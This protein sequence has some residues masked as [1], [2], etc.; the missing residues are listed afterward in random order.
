MSWSQRTPRLS[1]R[2]FL[3]AVF[4][5]SF[6]GLAAQAAAQV[7]CNETTCEQW[8]RW[9][10]ELRSAQDYQ[11]NDNPYRKLNI[12]VTYTPTSCAGSPWC[13]SFTG[14][15]FWDG[16]RVFRI[17]SAF[18]Q[19]TWH[20]ST[21]CSGTSN[22][23]NCATDPALNT[24]GD[25]TVV[26]NSVQDDP[27]KPD[28][29][30]LLERGFVR[31]STNSGLK[32]LTYG[33][34]Q[35]VFHWRA[36]TSWSA[37]IKDYLAGDHT[38]TKWNQFLDDRRNKGFTVIMM[39]SGS[40]A[41]DPAVATTHLFEDITAPGDPPCSGAA[42][43]R[44]CSRWRPLAFWQRLDEKIRLANEKGF[45][46][47][48]IGVMDPQGN[49]SNQPADLKYPNA[50]DAAI[51]ARNLSA[52]LAGSHVIYSPSFDDP[53][54]A[55]SSLIDTVGTALRNAAPRHLVTAHLAGASSIC[56]YYSLH[57]R[58][59]HQLHVFQSGHALNMS[60]CVAGEDAY[61]CAMRRARDIPDQLSPTPVVVPSCGGIPGPTAT[62]VKPNANGEAAYDATYTRANPQTV[63]SPYGV[64]HSGYNSALNGAFGVTLGVLGLYNWTN[65]SA[66]TLDSDGSKHMKILGDQFDLQPWQMLQRRSLRIKNQPPDT[67]QDQKMTLAATLDGNFAMAYMP[68]NVELKFDGTFLTG[69]DCTTAAWTVTWVNPK[70]GLPGGPGTCT[71]ISEP[72]GATRKLT[73][74][75]CT[76][77]GSLG[78]CDWVVVLRRVGFFGASA[79]LQ[80][81]GLEVWPAPT[82]DGSGWRIAARRK[83]VA[84][85]APGEEIAL[86]APAAR[87]Q[88]L[89]LP[90]VAAEA[91]GSYFV[92]WESGNDGDL[93]GIF[94]RRV[95]GQGR[96]L[97]RENAVNVTKEHDQTN[98]WAAASPTGRGGVVTWTSY[99]QDGDLG[100]VF[101]RLVDAAGVPYGKEIPVNGHTAGRQD[102]SK[103][104]M[105]D[106][107]GFVVAWTS[108]GQDGDAEGV[109]V[110]RFDAQGAP[111]GPE[112]RVNT[113]TA[114]AQWLTSLE[115]GAQGDVLVTWTS[116]APD[117]SELGVFGQRYD[118]KGLPVGGEYV[119]VPPPAPYK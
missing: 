26:N 103:A 47:V 104:V 23:L 97:G 25:V 64:R 69:F 60:N 56:D 83:G 58:S 8:Y 35:S 119:V 41:D 90:V 50:A 45:L 107:G 29:Y 18:P 63:D 40:S 13:Q 62:D 2:T 44:S 72:S 28:R 115:P 117:G 98:P 75:N 14:H 27:T 11:V 88:R 116:Y 46:V 81:S 118:A 106:R 12:T 21:S 70:T 109:Y 9:E 52:R 34:G 110:R 4:L 32:Y 7:T 71:N 48:L 24:S 30:D 38:N 78:D 55:T 91:G 31:M 22:G 89:K 80:G 85:S 101:A 67:D 16:G 99:G 76:G 74:P 105:D 39:A 59:W 15:G 95:D 113:T 5:F 42:Y 6:L 1:H 20:W 65:V 54:S 33:D 66:T 111:L 114:G 77:T 82:P 3:S 49:A 73:R 108:D 19:G 43:P 57:G 68:D 10:K 93:H 84:G 51:F 61:E 112:L 102:F 86:S 87:G 96:L 53:L 36:D 92:A 79:A 94:A 37:A 100:G 17:R